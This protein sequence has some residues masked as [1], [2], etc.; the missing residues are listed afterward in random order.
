[1]HRPI[2]GDGLHWFQKAGSLELEN[3][4]MARLK[5]IIEEQVRG[6]KS[7]LV[8]EKNSVYVARITTLEELNRQ[9]KETQNLWVKRLL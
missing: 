6:I 5:A 7:L 4:R 1:M 9:E 8:E 2:G 3:A